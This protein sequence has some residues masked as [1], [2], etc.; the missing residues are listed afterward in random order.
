[1]ILC[2]S[3]LWRKGQDHHNISSK[4]GN[5]RNLFQGQKRYPSGRVESTLGESLANKTQKDKALPLEK[6]N[7]M[8]FTGDVGLMANGD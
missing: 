5:K 4:V 3:N 2:V 1:M 8:H 7:K 6:F